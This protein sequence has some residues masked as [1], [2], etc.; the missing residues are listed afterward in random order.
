MELK[1]PLLLA[2]EGSDAYDVSN[3]LKETGRVTLDP[4]FVNTASC[5]SSITSIDGDAGILRLAI[6]PGSRGAGCE[7]GYAPML[8]LCGWIEPLRIETANH[9]LGLRLNDW[10]SLVVFTGAVTY[11]VIS[12]RRHPGRETLTG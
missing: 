11:F 7:V 12:A 1:C 5:R 6:Q 9:I 2:P 10:T 8:L 3:L 4:G